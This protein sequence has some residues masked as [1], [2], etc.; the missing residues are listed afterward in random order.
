MNV[1][2]LSERKRIFLKNKKADQKHCENWRV[3]LVQN[4]TNIPK[5]AIEVIG[6]NSCESSSLF[7]NL[8]V[9]IKE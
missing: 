2:A 7:F 3:S 8:R 4:F 6:E 9:F 5:C 1:L